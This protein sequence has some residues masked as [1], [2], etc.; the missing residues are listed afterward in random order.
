MEFT[1]AIGREIHDKAVAMFRAR[2]T[3][4]DVF[5]ELERLYAPFSARVVGIALRAFDEVF[6][7]FKQ[8]VKAANEKAAAADA[9]RQDD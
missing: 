2:A 7:E 5:D 4:S 3:K 1:E 6:E 8:E 9:R